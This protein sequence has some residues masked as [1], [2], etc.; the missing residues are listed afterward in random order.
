MFYRFE[1]GNSTKGA[2]GLTAIIEGTSPKNA[3]KNMRECLDGR[4][5]TQL[6]SEGEE[7]ANVYYNSDAVTEKDITAKARKIE[8]L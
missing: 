1:L 4:E 3:V 8:D 5:Y 2:I 6:F 7:Y